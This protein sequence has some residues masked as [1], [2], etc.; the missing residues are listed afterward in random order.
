MCPADHSVAL[1][2]IRAHSLARVMSCGECGQSPTMVL[3]NGDWIRC[4]ACVPFFVEG[5]CNFGGTLRVFKREGQTLVEANR[6]EIVN[7]FNAQQTI[8]GQI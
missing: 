7:F 4:N 8:N 5:M 1:R 6:Q 2:L 3:V